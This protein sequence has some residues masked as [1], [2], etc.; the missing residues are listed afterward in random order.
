MGESGRLLNS[1]LVMQAVS[2]GVELL[3]GIS[4]KLTLYT[5]T[6]DKENLFDNQEV[7]SLVIFSRFFY[8]HH[9]KV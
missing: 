4:L 1:T 8:S 6:S 7:V 9:V 2:E 3:F 5:L